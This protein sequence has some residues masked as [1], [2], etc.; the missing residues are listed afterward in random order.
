[1]LP[2]KGKWKVLPHATH[3]KIKAG[4]GVIQGTFRLFPCSCA[5]EVNCT[6]ES[7]LIPLPGLKCA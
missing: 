2:Y 1:M 6:E 4:E 7:K 3:E 5:V